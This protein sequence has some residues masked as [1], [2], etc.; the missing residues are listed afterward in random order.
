MGKIM[1]HWQRAE[2]EGSGGG[3][4]GGGILWKMSWSLHAE[5][6]LRV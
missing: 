2:I 5:A 3:G 1:M 6:G 4:G